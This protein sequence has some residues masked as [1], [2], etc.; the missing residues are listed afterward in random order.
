MRAAFVWA[1]SI[2]L[3]VYTHQGSRELS[4]AMEARLRSQSDRHRRSRPM[5]LP[6]RATVG[7]FSWNRSALLGY[8]G[9][10]GGTDEAT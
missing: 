4:P 2:V 5:I 3:V 10:G 8:G 6:M 9:G 1:F 7:L